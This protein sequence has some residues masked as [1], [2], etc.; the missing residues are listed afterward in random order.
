MKETYSYNG[1]TYIKDYNSNEEKIVIQHDKQKPEYLFKFYSLS[2]YNVE[3]LIKGYLYTSH[4]YELNDYLDSSQFLLFTSRPLDF[5]YYEKLFGQS[6]LNEPEKL[7]DFYNFDTNRD[8]LCIEYISRYW[9]ISSNI[10]GVISLTAK[11]NNLLMWPHY[12]NERGFQLKFDTQ[13]LEQSIRNKSVNGDFC[14]LHPINYVEKLSPIDISPFRTLFIPVFYC[15]N[16]KSSAWEYENEWRIAISKPQMG[17]PYSKAG[18]SNREDYLVEK[19]NRFT[20]YDFEAIEEITLGMNFFTKAFFD[21]NW[22]NEKV[23]EITCKN[24]DNG[25]HL[26]LLNF[27]SDKLHNKL[28]LSGVKYELDENENHFLIR[29]KE[30]IVIEKIEDGKFSLTR[31]NE[32]IKWLDT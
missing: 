29:T 1:F 4:P 14:G 28:F 3:S 8:N 22:V 6:F 12:T 24:E 16:V 9:H 7:K 31:T 27:I 11:E 2:N 32:V 18:L 19:E 30:K 26:E 5:N 15:I 23:I 25:T 21:I 20:Y 10:L 13:K 17:I